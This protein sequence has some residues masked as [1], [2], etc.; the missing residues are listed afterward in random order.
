MTTRRLRDEEADRVL[1]E[2][3]ATAS[4]ISDEAEHLVRDHQRVEE[5]N[6]RLRSLVAQLEAMRD[7]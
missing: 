7:A 6:A 1:A 5:S 3:I 4:S 2:V